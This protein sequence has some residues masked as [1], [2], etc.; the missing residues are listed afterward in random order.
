M[1]PA[2][3]LFLTMITTTSISLPQTVNLLLNGEI[4]GLND[5]ELRY[6][7]GLAVDAF[8]KVF[9]AEELNDRIQKFT[10]NGT[11]ITKLG[12]AGNADGRFYYPR[13]IAIDA[14]GNIFVS[15]YENHRIQKF[16]ADGQFL[17]KWGKV[18]ANGNPSPGAGNKEFKW[19]AGIAFDHDGNVYVVDSGN[20]RIQK[21]TADGQFLGKI[22]T[23]SLIL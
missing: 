11:F 18:D 10:G 13:G 22:D 12:S 23:D 1:L 5:G 6:P 2:I 9:V 15:D 16:T 8:G 21:F 19:P 17:D 14:T 7:N 20:Y 3:F 4:A